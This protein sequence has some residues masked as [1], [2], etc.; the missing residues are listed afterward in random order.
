MAY[1]FGII[2]ISTF[3]TRGISRCSNADYK[4]FIEKFTQMNKPTASNSDRKV[5]RQLIFSHL[6]DFT[7]NNNISGFLL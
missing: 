1:F 2:F 3:V 7:A 6:N 4:I 5:M